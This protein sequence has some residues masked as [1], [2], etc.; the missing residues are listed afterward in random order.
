MTQN[1]T[2]QL[3]SNDKAYFFFHRS[4]LLLR[5]NVPF[6]PVGNTFL[7]GRLA[8]MQ[9]SVDG[10]SLPLALLNGWIGLKRQMNCCQK[11]DVVQYT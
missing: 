1:F 8:R 7:G 11:V 5:F 4:K 10:G 6:R 3:T 2:T 9:A